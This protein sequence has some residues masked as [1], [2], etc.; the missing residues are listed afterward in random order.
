MAEE[1]EQG[2]PVPEVG[3][4]R[5]VDEETLAVRVEGATA[6]KLYARSVDSQIACNGRPADWTALREGQAIRIHSVQGVFGPPVITLV[7][8]LTGPMEEAVRRDVVGSPPPE[9]A[10]PRGCLPPAGGG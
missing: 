5:F 8:I 10:C 2:P 6:P 3:L 9:C 4:I 1:L 7:E